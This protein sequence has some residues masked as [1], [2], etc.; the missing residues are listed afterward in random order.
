[1]PIGAGF[2]FWF[3]RSFETEPLGLAVGTAIGFGALVL[4]LVRMRPPALAVEEGEEGQ[5][6][7]KDDTSPVSESKEQ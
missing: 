1:M 4:R 5:E 3:D 7:D 2:G 6:S